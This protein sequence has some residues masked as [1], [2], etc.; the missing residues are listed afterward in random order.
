MS[1]SR[2]AHTTA[3]CTGAGGN[4]KT[5]T[6][7]NID[8]SGADL[9]VI[10]VSAFPGGTNP[11][12]ASNKAGTYNLLTIRVV[13]GAINVR[14]FW[15][16]GPT[17][18]SGH[19]WTASTPA[20][21]V[22]PSISVEAW[23]GVLAA[24]TNDG[25]TGATSAGA[26]SLATG[27]MT[28]SQDGNLIFAAVGHGAN[29]GTNAINSGFTIGDQTQHDGT[30]HEGVSI[31]YFEQATAA[32]INPTWSWTNSVSVAVAIASFKAAV[33]AAGQP[34]MRRWGGVPHLGGGSGGGRYGS[35]RMWGR[36]RSGIYVPNHLREAA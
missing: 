9:I 33:V 30:N 8:T 4:F 20:T 2:I 34:T 23:S 21:N 25:D 10:A 14:L 24:S 22:F 26:T 19:N 5:V 31:A 35:G 29:S 28:P 27:S 12:V 15:A 6:T 32:A 18:G 36:T 17:V 1:W 7:P 13:G 3:G 11:T 16:V